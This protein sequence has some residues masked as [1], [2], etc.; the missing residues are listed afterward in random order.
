MSR[1]NPRCGSKNGLWPSYTPS[2]ENFASS[3]QSFSEIDSPCWPI[4]KPSQPEGVDPKNL[5]T[6]VLKKH[7]PSLNPPHFSRTP[8]ATPLHFPTPLIPDPIHGSVFSFLKNKTRRFFRILRKIEHKFR[9]FSL[10]MR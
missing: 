5:Q 3:I 7:S 10:R 6:P 1:T 2:S 9:F 8:Q 4:G